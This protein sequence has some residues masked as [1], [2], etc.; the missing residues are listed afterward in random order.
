M[1]AQRRARAR[2][3]VPLGRRAGVWC[4]LPARDAT[5]ELHMP[6]SDFALIPPRI[7]SHM[8]VGELQWSGSL[9]IV[10]G[11]CG[12]PFGEVDYPPL[13]MTTSTKDDRVHPYHARCFVK[14]LQDMGKGGNVYYY[15]N[16]EG[17][18]GGAAD[19]K[20]SAYVTSLYQNFLWKVLSG[21]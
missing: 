17:G 4:M 8:R 11:R 20:Q 18:H 10:G 7:S 15:E 6:S 16:I 21:K 9:T 2:R 12:V 5:I 19:A 3:C 1:S 13:L 14:R